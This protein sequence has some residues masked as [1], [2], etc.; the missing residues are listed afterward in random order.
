MSELLSG[1]LAPSTLQSYNRAWH[2]LL[3][4]ARLHKLS[5]SLPFSTDTVCLFV[6]QLIDHGSSANSIASTLSAISYF[7][8]LHNAADPC[9]NFAVRQLALA[10]QKSSQ[11]LPKRSAIDID[12]LAR[13]V[14]LALSTCSHYEGILLSSMLSLAFFLGLRLSEYTKS[15]H[16]L[17]ISQVALSENLLKVTFNSFKHSTPHQPPHLMY[18]LKKP[19]CPVLL[20]RQYL[21][22]RGEKEG[23]LFLLGLGAVSGNWFNGQLKGL[24]SKAGLKPKSFSSHSLRIGAANFWAD[25]NLSDLKIKQLGRWRANALP[26]YLRSA[27]NHSV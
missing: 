27:I 14:E 19:F 5:C 15:V 13:L 3:D 26:H 24:I 18:T 9:Q 4:F 16:N 1:A 25:S 23:P 20:L 21:T 17:Q 6:T 11:P 22:L 12:L 10:A 7:H 8:K 2:K